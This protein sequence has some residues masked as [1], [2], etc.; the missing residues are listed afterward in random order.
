MDYRRASKDGTYGSKNRNQ[1]HWLKAAW[2]TERQRKR[3]R[4]GGEGKKRESGPLVAG[5]LSYLDRPWVPVCLYLLLILVSLF[6]SSFSSLSSFLYIS[7]SSSFSCFSFS[8]G[9]VHLLQGSPPR[10]RSCCCYLYPWPVHQTD[11]QW[12]VV[13]RKFIRERLL[14]RVA[15]R[16]ASAELVSPSKPWR[17]EWSKATHPQVSFLLRSLDLAKGREEGDSSILSA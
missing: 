6:L 15:K 11:T 13:S 16:C 17:D 1:S 7:S 9:F 3:E 12:R 2:P 14:R 4:G 5:A 8:R 10:A